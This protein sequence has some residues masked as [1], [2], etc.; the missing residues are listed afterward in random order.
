MAAG[1]GGC[2][3]SGMEVGAATTVA[4]FKGPGVYAIGGLA[5][6]L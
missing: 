6:E 5:N 3:G 2:G 1:C 4:V